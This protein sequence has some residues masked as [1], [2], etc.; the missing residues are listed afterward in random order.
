MLIFILSLGLAISP[1][2]GFC[3]QELLMNRVTPTRISPVDQFSPLMPSRS[4]PYSS[5]ALFAASPPPGSGFPEVERPDPATL[6]AAQSDEL[7]RALAIVI[8]L[9]IVGGTFVV[10]NFLS[11]L[12]DDILPYGLLDTILGFTVPV[13]LGL[14]FVLLGATHFLN[15]D[16]YAAIVPPK[17][18]WGGV[19]NVPAPGADK[20][21]L[22]YAEYHTLWAGVAEIGGG[23]LFVLGGLNALPIQIPAFLLFV[24]TLAVTPA[25]VYMFTHDAQLSM[26]PP[27][28]YPFGHLARAVLQSVL[29][30]LFWFF[31]FQ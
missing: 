6:V 11:W 24:L 27:I 15:K 1:V 17:G 30:A 8:G 16:E 25:N 21:G 29:L 12:G 7:Q 22:T 20:L 14:L 19:W 5:V 9:G 26:A 31:A 10:V 28:E 13:P 3:C 2:C 23:L 18:S 4:S